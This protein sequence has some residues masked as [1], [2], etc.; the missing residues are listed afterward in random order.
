MMIHATKTF[1][2]GVNEFHFMRVILL[3]CSFSF[4]LPEEGGLTV[5]IFLGLG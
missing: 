5:I 4:S 1:E 3:G 2:I